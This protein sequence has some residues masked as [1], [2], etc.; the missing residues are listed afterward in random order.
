[1]EGRREEGRGTNLH[2]DIQ[3]TRLPRMR[4]L[5]HSRVTRAV[6]VA[7]E[8]RVLNEAAVGNQLLERF[9]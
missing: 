3:Y 4:N 7:A 1:V 8:L 5:L 9:A 2:L 6:Q